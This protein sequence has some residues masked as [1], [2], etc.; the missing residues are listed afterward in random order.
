MDL[1]GDDRMEHTQPKAFTVQNLYTGCA[2]QVQRVLI[3]AATRTLPIMLEAV[4]FQKSCLPLA[5]SSNQTTVAILSNHIATSLLALTKW[6]LDHKM[7]PPA[8]QMGKV[9]KNLIIDSTVGALSPLSLLR[10]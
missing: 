7:S 3:P 8:A 9:Y 1:H 6:W 4:I 2:Y 5:R 10:G